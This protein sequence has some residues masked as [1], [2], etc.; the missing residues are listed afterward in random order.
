MQWKCIW[1]CNDTRIGNIFLKKNRVRELS[2]P[3]ISMYYNTELRQRG[4]G[5]GRKNRPMEQYRAQNKL[6][7]TQAVDFLE[8]WH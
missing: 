2:L 1:K 4:P 6:K 7:H 8:R 3:G 5:N